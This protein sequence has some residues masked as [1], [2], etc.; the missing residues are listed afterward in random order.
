M[1]L[2]GRRKPKPPERIGLALGGG[3]VRGAAH[4]GVLSVLERE[5]VPIAMVAGTSV[6]AMVGA[7]LAAGIPTAEL[8]E[9]FQRAS[10]ARIATPAWGGSRL[11]LL[12]ANPLGKLIERVTNAET[13]EE[14]GLPYAAV[15][16][17]VLTG[18]R[19]VFR[20]G[21]LRQAVLAS[22]AVPGF[23]EPVRIDGRILADGGLV[24][25]L[26][27]DVVLEM[28]ADFVIAVDIMPPLDG[29]YMPG[30]MRDMLMLSLNIVQHVG[31][32]G[33]EHA[34][35]ISPA[36]GA[37]SLTD[38]GRAPDAYEAGVRAAEESLPQLLRS[39]AGESSR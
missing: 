18:E 6:G 39:L 5:N 13:I 16:C 3:A 20:T 4:L 19:V 25:N 11:G 26:P 21:P 38:F 23:F 31:E 2:F 27:I 29:T 36:V 7:G 33:R 24:D 28:G 15:A 9:R 8:W 14:L 12:D 22:A 1:G 34:V 10:W 17:D 32:Y 35:V 30:D 37:V